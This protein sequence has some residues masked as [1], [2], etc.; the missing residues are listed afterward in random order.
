MARDREFVSVSGNSARLLTDAVVHGTHTEGRELAEPLA[1]GV[2]HEDRE[3]TPGC[4]MAVD[5][6][7]IIA[8][9]EV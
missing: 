4:C 5:V 6:K 7:L 8:H 2:N 1:N 3:E 9:I